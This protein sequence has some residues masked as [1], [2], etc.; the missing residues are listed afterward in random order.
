MHKNSCFVFGIGF[1]FGGEFKKMNINKDTRYSRTPLT[2]E[3]ASLQYIEF[4]G[5]CRDYKEHSDSGDQKKFG[6]LGT[7][8]VEEDPWTAK[9]NAFQVLVVSPFLVQIRPLYIEY[10]GGGRL[11]VSIYFTS[12]SRTHGL[13]R[14]TLS[15]S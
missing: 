15:R 7:K 4:V 12:L 6:N 8:P 5:G 1:T 11:C 14:R 9:K 10:L 3:T 2:I 13:Q